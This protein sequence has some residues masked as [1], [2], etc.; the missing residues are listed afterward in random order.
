MSS[1]VEGAVERA[2]TAAAARHGCTC[3]KTAATITGWPDRLILGP[4]RPPLLVECKSARGQLRPRQRLVLDHLDASAQHVAVVASA[5]MAEAEVASWLAETQAAAVAGCL[6]RLRHWEVDAAEEI[7]RV[8]LR[9]VHVSCAPV[10]VPP[11][12]PWQL[13]EISEE[14]ARA[15]STEHLTDT[16]RRQALEVALDALGRI[17]CDQ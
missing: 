12:T 8:V 3:I 1:R 9:Q 2:L 11:Q 13:R 16:Q 4:G 6:R 14:V 15:V 5:E 7:L 10:A 17:D